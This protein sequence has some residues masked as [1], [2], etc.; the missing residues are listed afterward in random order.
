MPFSAIY[1]RDER[2]DTWIRSTGSRIQ[3]PRSRNRHNQSN[4]FFNVGTLFHF[5]LSSKYFWENVFQ[6]PYGCYSFYFKFIN[7]TCWNILYLIWKINV[8]MIIISY[9]ESCTIKLSVWQIPIYARHTMFYRN[10]SASNS[11]DSL[12][13]LT[14]IKSRHIKLLDQEISDEPIFDALRTREPFE[15]CFEDIHYAKFN[16]S[17][18]DRNLF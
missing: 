9:I 18:F 12:Y 5:V 15:C 17:W 2:T 8:A 1:W 14:I 4:P 6:K 13:S 16:S 3:D 10:S 11:T 7:K